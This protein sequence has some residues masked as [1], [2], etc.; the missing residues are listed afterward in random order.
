L[1][2]LVLLLLGAILAPRVQARGLGAQ[3]PQPSSPP[4]ARPIA[5]PAGRQAKNVAVITIAGP[6]DTPMA[7]SVE[8]RLNVAKEAGADAVVIELDTPGGEVGAVLAITA[9]IRTSP[10]ANIVAW[11]RPNAL[12]GGAIIAVSCRE[13]IVSDAVKFGDAAPINV[14]D[15]NMGASERAK[16]LAPV[17]A[18]VVD[19]AR[20]RGYDEKLVQGMVTLGAELWLVER[21]DRPGERLCIGRE[22]YRLIFGAEPPSMTPRLVGA[23]TAAG[24]PKRDPSATPSGNPTA[25]NPTAYN[26]T[27]HLPAPGT[28]NEPVFNIATNPDPNAGATPAGPATEVGKALIPAAP[29]MTPTLVRD[30]GL[31]LETVSRRPTLSDADRGKW[32]VVEYI[33]D[34]SGIFTLTGPDMAALGLAQT[35]QTKSGTINTDEELKDYFGATNLRRLTPSVLEFVASFLSNMIVRGLLIVIFLVGLFVEMIN[36]GMIFPATIAAGAL[37]LL[38]APPLLIGIGSWWAVVV[39]LLGIILLALELFVLPGFGIFGVLGLVCLFGGL[40]GTFL[41]ANE[42]LFPDSPK[43]RSDLLLGVMTVIVSTATAFVAMY[44]ISKHLGSLPLLNKFVLGPPGSGDDDG[45]FQSAA[46]ADAP[47]QVGDTGTALTALR[48]SGKVQLGD[49]I[50]DVVSDAGV[51]DA[52]VPVRVVEVTEFRITVEPAPKA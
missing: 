12:S 29:D 49:R 33:S 35:A 22:E 47:A 48:P 44:F 11:V 24:G 1:L 30:T 7:R 10:I 36:P 37:L 28:S 23:T 38:V 45:L 8:R 9:A 19:S 21:T 17:L 32:K 42:G 6:I 41:P 16:V 4:P 26:P 39:I 18:D 52:G 3:S 5:I 34:G 13:I 50:L 27:P 14:F 15:R 46:P 31:H 43:G 40:V 25:Q 51:I 20:A 2:A